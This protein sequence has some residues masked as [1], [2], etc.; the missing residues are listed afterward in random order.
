MTKIIH[1]VKQCFFYLQ[2]VCCQSTV[3]WVLAFQTCC[4]TPVWF[5]ESWVAQSQPCTSTLE[6]CFVEG[7]QLTPL[8]VW[9]K[10]IIQLCSWWGSHCKHFS[11][12][13]YE[14]SSYLVWIFFKACE[15]FAWSFLI[16]CPSSQMTRSAPGLQRAFWTPEET[17]NEVKGKE[18][19]G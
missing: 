18:P 15:I 11:I 19:Q 16:L 4:K 3:H 14:V 1:R 17:N 2:T 5:L 13:A 10:K 9:K 6:G 8:D 7:N 12:L